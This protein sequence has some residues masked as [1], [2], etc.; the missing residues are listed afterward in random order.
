MPARKLLDIGGS[1]V[2]VGR[3][4]SVKSRLG[5]QDFRQLYG[6]KKMVATATAMT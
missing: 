3:I 1:Q 5:A 2:E 4:V 6:Y